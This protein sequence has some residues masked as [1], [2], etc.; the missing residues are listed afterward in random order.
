MVL[1]CGAISG[2]RYRRTPPC[3]TYV[4]FQLSF[5]TH[6]EQMGLIN[7]R[8]QIFN[9]LKDCE[10]IVSFPMFGCLSFSVLIGCQCQAISY[11][12]DRP[13]TG[14]IIYFVPARQVVYRSTVLIA[15]PSSVEFVPSQSSVMSPISHVFH[16]IM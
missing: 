2:N 11:Q 1:G 4:T 13:S 14:V 3:L 15:S 9:G 7:W 5:T 8:R 10:L 6:V 16:L 12:L